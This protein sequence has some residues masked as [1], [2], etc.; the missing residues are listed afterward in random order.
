[1]IVKFGIL[2]PTWTPI[3]I[4]VTTLLYLLIYLPNI[5]SFQFIFFII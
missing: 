4:I 5:H 3:I 2:L 1:M